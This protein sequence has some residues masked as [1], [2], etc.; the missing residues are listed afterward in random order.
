[1]YIL[2]VNFG[3]LKLWVQNEPEMS[4]SEMAGGMTGDW[5]NQ[6]VGGEK[7]EIKSIFI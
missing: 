4:G 6:Q 7:M 1:M 3:S 2:C 5:K